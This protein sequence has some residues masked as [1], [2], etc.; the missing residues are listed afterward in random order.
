M[1]QI[2]TVDNNPVILKLMTNFLERQGYEVRTAENGLAAMEVLETFHPEVIFVDLIMPKIGG[3]KLCRI[4]RSMPEMD[5]VYLVILS[6]AVLENET[7]LSEFGADFCIAKGP[8][9]QVENHITA[10]LEKTKEKRTG[11][12]SQSIIGTEN[13]F[14]RQITSE[15]LRTQKHLEITL[16]AIAEGFLELTEDL[17]IIRLNSE[18]ARL[19]A[20]CEEKL[21][22]ASFLD[23][24]E[25]EQQPKLLDL[26][27]NLHETPLMQSEES[28]LRV[29]QREVVLTL[30]P[31][32]DN[33]Q[34]SIIVIITDITERLKTAEELYRHRNHL[35]EL[36]NER[37]AELAA[38][39]QRLKEEINRRQLLEDEKIKLEAACMQ[40]VK[41][42]ALGTMA[43]GV[44]HDFSDILTGINGFVELLKKETPAES[45]SSQ[46]LSH[47]SAAVE[48]AKD[49]TSRILT[50]SRQKERA[51]SLVQPHLIIKEALNFLLASLPIAIRV[52]EEISPECGFILGDAT[53]LHQVLLNLFSNA[54]QAMES[55]GDTLR[56]SLQP[57]ISTPE[58]QDAQRPLPPGRYLKIS[59]QDNGHGMD[60]NTMERIFDP[61]F[62]TK[63]ADKGT[64]LGLAVTLGIVE[65]HGGVI[66][67]ESQVGKGSIFHVFLPAAEKPAPQDEPV[68]SSV[69]IGRGKMVQ[70]HEASTPADKKDEKTALIHNPEAPILVVDD[71]PV[72]HNLYKAI[73]RN[74][75]VRYAFSGQEALEIMAREKIVV[76]ISDVMMPGMSGIELL[77]EIKKRYGNRV[78]VIM[79]TASEDMNHLHAAFLAGANDFLLKPFSAVDIQNVLK[80]TFAKISRWKKSL[81]Q[82]FERQ[83]K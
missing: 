14:R 25:R 70:A 66:R 34:K 37:T 80:S 3:E 6:G 65:S 52:E 4:L 38:S 45:D 83:Q 82:L 47:L 12:I 40:K 44:A 69:P 13:V 59:V 19:F 49:L 41:M 30:L 23:L 76:V 55:K 64:G 7:Q 22:S 61:Y 43:G 8:F 51:F 79:V 46:Y 39:N 9:K 33:E 54:M 24:I 35:T 15:L 60:A 16:D 1:R 58:N 17:K 81:H 74:W 56:I 50:F 28:P 68:P 42:E 5:D 11:L 26:L 29:N 71:N 10:L 57:F 21:L 77:V 67:V 36:V 2:L 48:R 73:L 53:Q 62:T 78:Q 31:I 32:A 63:E 18:A 20:Q 72:L 27:E 75:L